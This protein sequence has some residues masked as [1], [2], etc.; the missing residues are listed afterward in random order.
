MAQYST[1]NFDKYKQEVIIIFHTTFEL[2]NISHL[3]ELDSAHAVSILIEGW[4]PETDAHHIGNDQ[5]DAPGYAR[6]TRQ[7]NLYRKQEK[8]MSCK[9]YGLIKYAK[10]SFHCLYASFNVNNSIIS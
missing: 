10:H 9:H 7:T 5:K 2:N 4:R 6:F 8:N 1:D 3:A